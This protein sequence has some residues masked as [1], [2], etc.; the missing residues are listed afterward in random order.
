M[1]GFKLKKDMLLGVAACAAQIEGGD[2]NSNWNDWYRK[3]NIKD[4][5]DP[6]RANDHYNRFREDA[7]LM[8]SLGIQTYRLGVEWSRIEPERGNYSEEALKHYRE[9][10]LLMKK[11][12]IHPL[13]TLHH[14]SN[15]MWFEDMG[16]F[17]SVDA[18][19]IFLGFVEKVVSFLG[20]IV[21]EYITINEPNVYAVMGYFYGQWPPGKK[22]YQSVK[23][24]YRN[25]VICH[26]NAYSSI[27]GIRKGMGYSDTKISFANHIR[28]FKPKCRFNLYHIICAK[29]MDKMFQSGLTKSLLLG[30]KSFPAGKIPEIREGKYYDFIAL[31]YYTRSTVSGF[32]DGVGKKVPVN[33]LGWEVHPEGIVESAKKLYEEYKAP[34]YITENGTCD[35]QDRFRCR[36]IYDHLKVLC[37]SDLPVK[38]YY[39]WCFIDNFEWIE[40]ESARFGLVFLDY[41]T[42]KRTVKKSGEFYREIILNRGVTDEMYDKYAKQDYNIN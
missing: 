41:N 34:I 10:I 18:P 6:A 33:D 4:G 21:N 26:I 19:K 39:H 23:K 29:L 25:L 3:G 7:D 8:A 31:N 40:G 35:N 13:L 28:I 30:K 38:R 42:Q 5:S 9:E 20:D 2:T 22:S 27:H 36:Y 17:E 37:E 24:V 32:K 12:G 16:G 11:R 15:P 14:F 1:Q